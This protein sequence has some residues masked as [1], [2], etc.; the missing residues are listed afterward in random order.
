MK[1]P[2]DAPRVAGR[3]SPSHADAFSLVCAAVDAAARIYQP[4]AIPWGARVGREPIADP[5]LDPSAPWPAMESDFR[6]RL[7]R[8]YREV[9]SLANDYR[10]AQADYAL[11]FPGRTLS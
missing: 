7:M 2:S 1:T 5:V 3:A 4:G 6:S 10:I 8:W 9:E 11:M